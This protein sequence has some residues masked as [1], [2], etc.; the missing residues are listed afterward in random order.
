LF[1]SSDHQSFTGAGTGTFNVALTSTLSIQFVQFVVDDSR[2]PVVTQEVQDFNPNFSINPQWLYHATV[3]L[4]GLKNGI[5]RITAVATD[6]A[7]G[8]QTTSQSFTIKAVY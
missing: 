3:D 4:S 2:S 8:T 1:T 7:G 6:V 5:H